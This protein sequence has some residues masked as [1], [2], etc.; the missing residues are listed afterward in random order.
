MEK[1]T[2]VMAKSAPFCWPWIALISEWDFSAGLLFAKH[3]KPPS[4]QTLGGSLSSF[5]N[6]MATLQ[7]TKAPY[8]ERRLS[9]EQPSQQILEV[10]SSQWSSEDL[11]DRISV[12]GGDFDSEELDLD[13]RDDLDD[14]DG[15]DSLDNL[16]NELNDHDGW[17]NATG[18]IEPA[19]TYYRHHHH[20]SRPAADT[21]RFT[22]NVQ[23]L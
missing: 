1:G 10:P 9:Y 3:Y 15:L 20:M 22:H 19:F 14:L 2:E 23:Y 7:S 18:G 8:H 12:E 4:R 11:V 17:D 21:H 13:D 5:P 6:T 16:E